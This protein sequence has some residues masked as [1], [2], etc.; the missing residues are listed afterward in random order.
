VLLSVG[1]GIFGA[2]GGTADMPG[3]SP[4]DGSGIGAFVA[5]AGDCLSLVVPD[6]VARSNVYCY[7]AIR[8][9]N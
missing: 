8:C 4:A 6:C 3:R 9:S 2:P 5:R 1:Q 7:S